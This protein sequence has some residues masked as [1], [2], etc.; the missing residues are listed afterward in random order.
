[1]EVFKKLLIFQEE[2]PWLKNKKNTTVI[3]F[4]IFREME[5]SSRKLKKNF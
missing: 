4:L 3:K 5:L 1:M 2:F